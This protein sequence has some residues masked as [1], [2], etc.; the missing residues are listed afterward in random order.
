LLISKDS[1]FSFFLPGSAPEDYPGLLAGDQ[2]RLF[3][4]EAFVIRETRED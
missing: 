3:S 4:F 1:A 2:G